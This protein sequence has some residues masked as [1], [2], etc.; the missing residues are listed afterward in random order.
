MPRGRPRTKPVEVIASEVE[1]VKE[2]IAEAAK[3]RASVS[4][5]DEYYTMRNKKVVLIKKMSNGNSHSLYAGGEFVTKY[6]SHGEK[7]KVKN[8][9]ID[10]A[11]K[12]GTWRTEE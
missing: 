6:N 2:T 9:Q 12:N 11:K 10:R 5:L 1:H 7:I 3:R 8:P 4:V